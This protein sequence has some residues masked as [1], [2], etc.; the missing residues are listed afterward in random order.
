M[1][2]EATEQLSLAEL[3]SVSPTEDSAVFIG[4]TEE[5]GML[6]IYGGHFV[7]QALSAGFA[8][9]EEPKLAHSFHCYFLRKGD[10]AA[11][12]EYHVRS[13]RDGYGSDVRSISARQ[14]GH[15]VFQMT[16][17]F[18]RPEM[19]SEHQPT[20]P[21][22]ISPSEARTARKA[23]GLS[24]AGAPTVK[25]G[26]SEL[27]PITPSFQEFD[28][29]REAKIQQWIR[30]PDAS[31]LSDRERQAVLAFLSDGTLM[32]NANIPHGTPFV[33]HRLTTLDHSAW[34]HR[35]PNPSDWMLFDQRSTAAADG[36][37]LN[38]GEIYGQD[39]TLFMSCA[40]ESMLRTV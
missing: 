26:R 25:N 30:V 17:S 28:P 7:G 31:E 15:E 18:K 40:Q 4:R 38:S 3:M 1:T 36:R 14:N 27:E 21:D 10:P 11:L 5:Y 20:M 2:S 29:N 23:A 39:G 6:G 16:A 22:V 32:F 35:I 34:F 12:L 9:V 8:T 19:G 24:S 33:T 13:L 37:G